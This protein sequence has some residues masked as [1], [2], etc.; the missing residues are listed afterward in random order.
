MTPTPSKFWT[1]ALAVT[2]VAAAGLA[3][4]GCSLLNQATNTTQRDDSG[5]PTA[6]NSDA[7]VFSIKVGD[8]LDDAA[9]NGTTTT[10]PI[11]PCSEP[12]DSEAFKSIIMA[13]GDY[14][15]DDAVKQQSEDGCTAAFA[16]FV[17]ISYD[18]S[19]L[20]VSYYFPTEDSWGNGDREIMCTVSDT[21][22]SGSPTRST[23]SLKGAAR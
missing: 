8:C 12:H 22:A 20:N 6:S 3:L 7:D 15:G 21:D 13:D 17:G 5:H 1:R 9:I 14:P 19:T 16:D 10:T 11:V 18:D 2:A 23:G 4:A